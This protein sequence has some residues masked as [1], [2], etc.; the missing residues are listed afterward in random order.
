ME[1]CSGIY[2]A[3]AS[4][5]DEQIRLLHLNPAAD[6]SSP[7]QC[8]F[9]IVSMVDK[10]CY[11]ALSYVWGETTYPKNIRMEGV[12]VTVTNNLFL[13]L[14]KLRRHNE[15]R[16]LWVDALCINQED[17]DE[18]S[19]QVSLMGSIYKEAQNVAVYL[20]QEWDGH[21]IAFDYLELAAAQCEY[22]FSPS[23]T[24]RLEV[25][26]HDASSTIMRENLIRFFESQWFRRVWT[27]QEY[28]LAKRATFQYGSTVIESQRV[29]DAF[30]NLRNHA[31]MDCCGRHA[32]ILE[33]SPVYGTNLFFALSRI[34]DLD[35][36][37][38][39]RNQNDVL[40]TLS[41]YRQ[42]GCSDARDRVYGILGMDFRGRGSQ[43]R[44]NYSIEVKNLFVQLAEEQIHQ[45]QSL[46]VLTHVLR[47]ENS[48]PDLPSYVPDWNISLTPITLF[49]CKGRALMLMYYNASAEVS[50]DFKMTSASQANAKGM[51]VDR[52][53]TVGMITSFSRIEDAARTK[54]I[55]DEARSLSGLPSRLPVSFQEANTEEIA[56]WQTLC[57]NLSTYMQGGVGVYEPAD[58]S[59]D[60]ERY[61][62]WSRLIES[63]A[64]HELDL[65]SA[66]V[67]VFGNTLLPNIAA[68][69]FMRTKKGLMG[70]VPAE[71]LPGDPVVVLAGGKVPYVLREQPGTC[72][73]NSD[74]VYS[75]LG[76]A[77]V[78]GL[79]DGEAVQN[80]PNWTFLNL[81]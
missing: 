14:S 18:R 20:G 41:M 78:T 9:K 77:Y 79:M 54:A 49:R 36:M 3:F 13:A 67:E 76:D 31:A 15:D 39:Y 27:V 25:G 65:P 38:R 19:S 35:S 69:R 42:R 64:N 10:P 61:L 34:D 51:I 66:D 11:E 74:V 43:I 59:V 63:H 2:P 70:F 37:R 23:M 72:N 62:R 80:R 24:P 46:D 44:P 32:S 22:H 4:L 48:V 33:E 12:D 40:E 6:S 56:F 60:Y 1:S 17:I 28:V 52:I 26:G 16:V 75:F 81:V 8:S 47:G 7:V 71:S 29:Q 50:A 58:P 30:S 45:T 55:V 21:D 53:E 68:R 5:Q 57:G 73:S